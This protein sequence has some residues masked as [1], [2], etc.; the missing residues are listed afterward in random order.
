MVKLRF[1]NVNLRKICLKK[2]LKRD[3]KE[4]ELKWR[5]SGQGVSVVIKNN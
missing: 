3:Y 1:A 4:L 2:N 5:V